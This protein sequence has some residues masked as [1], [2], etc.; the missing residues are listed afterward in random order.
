MNSRENGSGVTVKIVLSVS[1]L[2]LAV[3]VLVLAVSVLLLV[4]RFDWVDSLSHRLERLSAAYLLDQMDDKD[5]T[6]LNG[7]GAPGH[8]T[9]ILARWV[10]VV[11][12]GSSECW[13]AMGDGK[14]EKDRKSSDF[15][16]CPYDFLVRAVVTK[17]AKCPGIEVE[18]AFADG[19]TIRDKVVALRKRNFRPQP[20]L[21]KVQVC[22]VRLNGGKNPLSVTFPDKKTIDVTSRWPEGAGPRNIVAF[23]D[24]GCRADDHQRCVKE[25]WRF[26]QLAKQVVDDTR[27]NSV[28]P[29]LVLYLGDFMYVKFDAWDT[30][31]ASFFDPA[32][33]LLSAA[34]WIMVRGNHERCGEFG[35]T[36]HGYYL[37]FNTG[38][39]K[40]CENNTTAGDL[41]LTDTYAVDLSD[42]HR[43]IV[44][45]S[46][47]SFATDVRD[48]R[49]KEAIEVAD[50]DQAVFD[51]VKRMLGQVK[52]LAHGQTGKTVWL[53]THVPVFALEE[54]NKDDWKKK[55]YDS[56]K[57]CSIISSDDI[58]DAD[59]PETSAMMRVAW[60]SVEMV[61]EGTG[62]STILAADRHLF[63]AIDAGD[64][65]PLQITV[66]TGGVNLDPHPLADAESPPC[67]PKE[68]VEAPPSNLRSERVPGFARNWR[69]CSLEA[70]G[71]LVAKNTNGGTFKMTFKALSE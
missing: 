66:G 20:G 45:D 19:R 40:N 36:P 37:F 12:A 28:I 54:C 26:A 1:I 52:H 44:A 50:R 65:S 53:A 2:V 48:L 51:E 70:F 60:N 59:S 34:P 58:Y 3:S 11:P 22:Q 25:K 39:A 21:D 16:S 27:P 57:K 69:H 33:P 31:K 41:E 56:T 8:A 47:I 63:Q 61:K 24:T 13:L 49:E 5:F 43:V 14:D 42:T 9:K 6:W 46:A 71:Y 62:I 7:P 17:G 68:R 35:D 30:W 18:V 10:Q 55:K 23:G 4:A 15:G 38:A 67:R 29:D 64:M 32:A